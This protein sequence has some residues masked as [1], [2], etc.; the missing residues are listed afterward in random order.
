[1]KKGD[2]LALW[3][4]WKTRPVEAPQYDH[5]LVQSVHEVSHDVNDTT[6]D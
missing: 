3:K 4:E 2:M 6:M 5:D 1:M